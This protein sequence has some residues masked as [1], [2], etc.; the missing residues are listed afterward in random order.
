M[1]DLEKNLKARKNMRD[2]EP[3][4]H[5]ITHPI[6]I[7]MVANAILFMGGKDI[8][9]SHPE[10]A[11]VIVKIADLQSISLGNINSERMIALTWHVLPLTRKKSP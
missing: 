5:A 1:L 2:K 3:L 9:A 4:I 11:G 7:N 10:E 8:C 6:S